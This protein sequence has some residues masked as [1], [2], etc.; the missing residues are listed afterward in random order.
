MR[1]E[2]VVRG[3]LGS[4][5]EELRNVHFDLKFGDEDGNIPGS[6]L[7]YPPQDALLFDKQCGFTLDVGAGT[8]RLGVA[9]KKGK[10]GQV[11]TV[12]VCPWRGAAACVSAPAVA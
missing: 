5:I 1:S 9:R 6:L 8:W 7:R 12:D 10:G 11:R 3:M 4:A 2:S